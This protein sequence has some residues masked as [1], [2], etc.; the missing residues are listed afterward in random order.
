MICPKCKQ[1]S[2]SDAQGRKGATVVDSYTPKGRAGESVITRR[3]EC[4][5]CG[6]RFSTVERID[7]SSIEPRLTLADW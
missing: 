6:H 3:R 2:S 1:D 7:P 5:Q 4:Q